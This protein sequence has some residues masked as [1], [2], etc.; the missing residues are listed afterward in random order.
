[1]S[2][3]KATRI[4]KHEGLYNYRKN[5]YK[6]ASS[7]CFIQLCFH[8]TTYDKHDLTPTQLV[9]YLLATSNITII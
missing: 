6:Y 1:M 9:F 3:V 4:D 2:V 5:A 7:M 8:R